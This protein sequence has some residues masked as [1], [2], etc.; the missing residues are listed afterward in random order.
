MLR[1]ATLLPRSRM[2]CGARADEDD[3]G[4]LAG[5][6]ELGRF[7]QQAIA[8]VDRIGARDAGD[9]DILVDLQVGLDRALALADQIGLVGLEAV[10]RQLV[11]FGI[12]GDG[13]DVQLVGRAKHA[14]GDFAAIGDEDF[15]DRHRC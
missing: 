2:V 6:G 12:A 7:R 8:G 4:I 15:L 3:A 13:L 5:L 10:Q 14:D 11:L 1:A 9:A